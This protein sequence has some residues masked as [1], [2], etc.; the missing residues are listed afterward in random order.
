[1]DYHHHIMR[2]R[3]VDVA[4]LCIS[5][6]LVKADSSLWSPHYEGAWSYLSLTTVYR[7]LQV[8]GGSEKAQNGANNDK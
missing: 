2:E 7:H 5:D 3:V 4:Q 1:M 8:F 6:I